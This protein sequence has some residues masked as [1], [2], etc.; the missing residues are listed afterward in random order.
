MKVK[1]IS[2][3]HPVLGNEDDVSGKFDPSYTR[4]MGRDLVALRFEFKLQNKTLEKLLKEKRAVFTVEVECA[5]TFFRTVFSTYEKEAVFQIDA[6]KIREAVSLGFF[7]R[8]T[9]PIKNYVIDGCHPDYKGFSF[10]IDPGDVLAIA[11]YSEFIA[12]KDFDPLKP[13]ISSFI[14][15]KENTK[16]EHGLMEVDYDDPEKITIRLAKSDWRNYLAVK[17]RKSAASVL[18]ASIVLPVLADAILLVEKGDELSQDSHW[19]KR[20]NII[21]EQK[22][23]SDEKSPLVAAQKILQLPIERG[24]GGMIELSDQETD[25]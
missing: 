9:E 17:T 19:F 8:A 25:E 10:E 14:A 5:S 16:R 15:I 22:S 13:S 12:E 4:A 11:G 6:A 20:L 2:Y 1:N 23:L 18:H 7:I 24:L 3:P 21:L